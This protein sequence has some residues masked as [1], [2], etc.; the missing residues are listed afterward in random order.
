M[1]LKGSQHFRQ[2]LVLAT[3][4]GTPILI[5]EIRSD[6]MS[7]GLRPH[8]VTLLRLIEEISD[9]VIVVLNETGKE[10]CL[11]FIVKGIYFLIY[12]WSLV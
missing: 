4:S 8:E 11:V 1:K 5:D 2:R 3:L 7:P 9:D 10:V 6:D 12:L